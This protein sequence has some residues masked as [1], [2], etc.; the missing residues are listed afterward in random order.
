[1]TSSEFRTVM[2]RIGETENIFLHVMGEP[3]LHPELEEILKIADEYGSSVK[4]TT[5]GTLLP[6]RSE[7]ISKCC[8]LKTVCISLHSFE[9]NEAGARGLDEYL[10]GCLD[11]ADMLAS[12]GKYAVFR[13]WNEGEGGKSELNA[14]ILSEIDRRYPRDG[15]TETHRGMRV[16]SHIFVE[17]GER[18]D[19][20]ESSGEEGAAPIKNTSARCY[21]LSAQVAVLSDGTVVPCCLDRD[22]RLALGNIFENELSEII[23]SDTAKKLMEAL[24]ARIFP[25]PLC[26]T[27]EFAAKRGKHG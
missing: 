10:G 13:L 25:P 22:G 26:H 6:K 15:W 1:M 11:A 14:R 8:R 21:G 2:D 16:S 5:N 18:F 7:L 23:A 27:C 9:A 12:A 4:I 17:Y 19:W 20:P 3:L 24:R